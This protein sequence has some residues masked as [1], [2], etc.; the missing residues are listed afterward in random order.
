MA[1]L[2]HSRNLARV[3]TDAGSCPWCHIEQLEADRDGWE[4][5]SNNLQDELDDAKA[6]I[7]ELEAELSAKE[8]Y[9]LDNS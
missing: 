7:R 6:T 4:E 9:I 8:Q 3:L 2:K 5:S 1:C